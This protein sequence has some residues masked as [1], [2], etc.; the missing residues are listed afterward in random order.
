MVIVGLPITTPVLEELESVDA[1][2]CDLASST[3]AAARLG[4]HRV[5]QILGADQSRAGL[6]F[7]GGDANFDWSG[8]FVPLHSPDG[9]FSVRAGG[10]H[11]SAQSGIEHAAGAIFRQAE[12]DG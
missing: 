11:F 4:R 3:P 8:V 6:I 7:Y 9:G 5:A 1:P 2:L 10:D 12:A